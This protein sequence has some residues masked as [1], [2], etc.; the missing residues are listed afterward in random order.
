M[1]SVK[2]SNEVTPFVNGVSHGKEHIEMTTKDTFMEQV[3]MTTKDTFMKQV[4]NYITFKIAAFI[5][6]YWFPVLVPIGI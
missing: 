5:D 2:F 1:E 3:E 4:E 6:A